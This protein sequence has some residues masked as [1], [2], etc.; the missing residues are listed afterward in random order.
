MKMPNRNI[1]KATAGPRQFRRV[2]EEPYLDTENSLIVATDGH[3]L[4]A[5]PVEL[6][7]GDTSGNVSSEAIKAALKSS[8]V[9]SRS[10]KT[11]NI[12]AN[13][14]LELDN[15]ATYPR[16]N[17]GQFPDYKRIIPDLDKAEM[18]IS[19]DAKLLKDLADAINTPGSS[20]VTLHIKD[21]ATAFYVDSDALSD[22]YGVIMPCKVN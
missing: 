6:D 12:K 15:G 19:L 22:C 4:A 9:K 10:A 18:V 2:M 20:I 16:E 5:C 1:S 7:E 17:L 3:I 8:P 13:G 21:N 14:S 11:A